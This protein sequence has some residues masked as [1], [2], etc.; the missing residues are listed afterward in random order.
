MSDPRDERVWEVGFDGHADAQRR[1]LASL[2]LSQKL[3]WLEEAQ[4][5]VRRLQGQPGA[6]REPGSGATG[7]GDVHR[8]R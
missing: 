6:V 5:R 3:D 8:D 4:V 1:R 2:S 7:P